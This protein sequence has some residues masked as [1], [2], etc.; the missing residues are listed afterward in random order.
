MPV[1]ALWCIAHEYLCEVLI[2][3]SPGE[4]QAILLYEITVQG[5]Q[6]LESCK[7]IRNS[8]NESERLCLKESK[9]LEVSSL[10]KWQCHFA[11]QNSR[12]KKEAQSKFRSN[13]LSN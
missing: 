11:N 13:I 2:V 1:V 5:K 4:E 6:V 8:F 3:K 12:A 7:K 9:G 10:L